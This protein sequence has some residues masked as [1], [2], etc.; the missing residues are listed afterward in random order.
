M[1]TTQ[2]HTAMSQSPHLEQAKKDWMAK[3]E[4]AK[5]VVRS[6]LGSP[7]MRHMH[8]RSFDHVGRNCHFITVFGRVLLGEGG[9]SEAEDAVTKR[10]DDVTKAIERKISAMTV[11]IADNNLNEQL[12]HFNLVADIESAIVVPTQ[13]RYLKILQLGDEL[14][15]LVNTLWLHG[16]IADKDK[17]KA[18]LELKQLIRSIP[19]TTRKMRQ[20]LQEQV[21]KAATSK[22]ATPAVKA[23]LAASESAPVE[24]PEA[25]DDEE[26]LEAVATA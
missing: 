20:Y 12:A 22:N 11:V 14:L 23:A 25:G 1:S 26:V 8:K 2:P 16:E 19:H 15:V 18:E 13:K 4:G 17:S 7:T 6:P 5:L 24:A 3:F 10:I 21:R 9:I